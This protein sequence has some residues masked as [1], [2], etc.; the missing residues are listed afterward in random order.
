[1]ISWSRFF[2]CF[3]RKKQR[4]N[5]NHFTFHSWEQSKTVYTY[6][7]LH[8][9]CVS[10]ETFFCFSSCWW[11]TSNNCEMLPISL[12]SWVCDVTIFRNNKL[13]EF[14]IT[15]TGFG[16]KMSQWAMRILSVIFWGQWTYNY[17]FFENFVFAASENCKYNI[18]YMSRSSNREKD[19]CQILARFFKNIVKEFS[20]VVDWDCSFTKKLYK[21]QALENCLKKLGFPFE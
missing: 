20:E 15:L 19:I 12:I 17:N 1:M 8:F 18:I 4:K 7:A 16:E 13:D 21:A 9:K 14:F 10:S 11:K 6:I 3:F 2:R 5:W